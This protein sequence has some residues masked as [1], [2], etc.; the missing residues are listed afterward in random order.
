M[1]DELTLLGASPVAGRSGI[2]VTIDRSHCTPFG[3]MYG[4]T[5]IALATMAAEYVVGL[6]ARWVTTQFVASPRP[7]DRIDFAVEVEAAGRMTSQV[8]VRA[9][10]DGRTVMLSVST[11]TAR[12]EQPTGW[13]TMPDSPPPDECEAMSTPWSTAEV[14]PTGTF[15]ERLERRLATR[16]PEHA[17]VTLWTRLFDW[18]IGSAASQAFVADIV[19]MALGAALDAM[20]G[21]SSLDNTIRIVRGDPSDG[22][23]LLDVEAEG[24]GSGIGHGRVR[25]WRPDGTLIGIGS[26]S[27]ILRDTTPRRD[28][29]E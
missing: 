23:I 28:T 15:V 29:T 21:A 8:S 5:G 17:R 18:P 2:T 20:P 4:G 9:V 1:T 13:G 25:L 11:H 26:Q 16:D 12:D 19:P 6:P 3:F 7:G 22:W 24:F 14:D 27:A 10:C